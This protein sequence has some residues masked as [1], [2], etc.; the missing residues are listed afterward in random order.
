MSA[1]PKKGL[2]TAQ[3]RAAFHQMGGEGMAQHMRRD[4]G[5]IEPGLQ[6]QAFQQL[7][8]AAGG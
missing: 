6:R 5:R 1:W 4:L 8:K 3:I 2:H 7:M